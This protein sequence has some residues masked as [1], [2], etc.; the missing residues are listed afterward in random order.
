MVKPISRK[1]ILEKAKKYARK[2]AQTVIMSEKINT[3]GKSIILKR[4]LAY[5]FVKTKY[6]QN[7]TFTIRFIN[8]T[9]F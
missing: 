4:N 6:F 3:Q 8:Y 2:Y 5:K 7:S 1:R 9:F